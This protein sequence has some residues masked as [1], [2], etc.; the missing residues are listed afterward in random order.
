MLWLL[1]IMN[2][3]S[4]YMGEFATKDYY[5]SKKCTIHTF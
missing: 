2:D 3:N 5:E 4:K 1:G